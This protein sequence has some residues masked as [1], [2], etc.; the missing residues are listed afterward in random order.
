MS[1]SE[2]DGNRVVDVRDFPWE[3]DRDDVACNLA[4]AHLVGNL[5]RHLTVEGRVHAE[6]YVAAVGAIAGF[7]AQRTLFETLG[8]GATMQAATTK[9]GN[10]YWFGDALNDMLVPRA[11]SDA[12][13]KVW[14]IAA[15]AAASAGLPIAKMPDERKMFAHVA[16]ALG[17][18]KEGLPSVA[19]K[20]HPQLPGRTLLKTVWP[21]ALICFSGKFPG[22]DHE[23]G[24]APRKWWSA[25]AARASG[26]PIFDVKEVLPPDIAL[27]ILM[28][29]AIYASKLD[30]GTIEPS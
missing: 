25:I 24:M 20:H 26:R 11:E 14:S 5:P 18:E 8:P 2:T 10:R 29:T 28:E 15:G 21:L 17:G 22:T 13:T 9:D 12:G 27:T 3:G 19:P 4:L 23:Y 30:R 1:D 7:A 16:S 6:T